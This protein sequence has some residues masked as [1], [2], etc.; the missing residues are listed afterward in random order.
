MSIEFL[1]SSSLRCGASGRG[2]MLGIELISDTIGKLNTIYGATSDDNLILLYVLTQAYW[3]D[4]GDWRLLLSCCRTRTSR[5][6]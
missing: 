2:G 6:F 5:R 3:T 1:R 4:L